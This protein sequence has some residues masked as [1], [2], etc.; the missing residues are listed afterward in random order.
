MFLLVLELDTIQGVLSAGLT[1]ASAAIADAG[2]AMG[3]LAVG[4]VEG[5]VTVGV[6]PALGKVTSLWMTGESD[7]EKA[8]EVSKLFGIC[9]LN[10]DD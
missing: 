1:V 9:M 4:G 6:M 10:L 7:V 5:D 2:I 8:C 3:G